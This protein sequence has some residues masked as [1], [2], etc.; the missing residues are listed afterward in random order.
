MVSTHA[1]L[2]GSDEIEPPSE[3][4]PYR[5]EE[6]INRGGFSEIWLGRDAARRSLAIRRLMNTSVFNFTERGR[7]FAGCEVLQK[8]QGNDLIIGYIAHGTLERTPYLA[9]EYVEASNLKLL[10]ARTDDLLHEYLGNILIDSARALEHVH[11]CGYM[12]LDFKPEN[13][14]VS[15]NA[16]IKLIDFD[17]AQPRPETPRKASKNPGTPAYMSPEQ[18]LRQP[19]DHR[20]DIFAFGVMAYELVTLEKPFPGDSP[21]EILRRQLDRSGFQSPRDINPGVPAALD[22]TILK[23]LETDPDSRYPFQSVVVRDLERALYVS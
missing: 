8:L 21:D 18:L 15:R 13:I 16:N 20:A 4:G 10:L 17:L 1:A 2:A 6:L 14:L 22:K 5:L 19:Y 9:M 3:F 11:D 23:C 7:F 12:H